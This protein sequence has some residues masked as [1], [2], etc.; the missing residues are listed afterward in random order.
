MIFSV[1]LQ[2]KNKWGLYIAI[3]NCFVSIIIITLCVKANV[4]AVEPIRPY[5]IF[6]MRNAEETCKVLQ[7]YCVVL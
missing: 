3:T 4:H 6:V 2:Y 5:V 1:F 7:A